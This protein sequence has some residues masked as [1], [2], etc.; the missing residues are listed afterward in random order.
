[1]PDVLS[2][3]I[4]FIEHHKAGSPTDANVYWIH[5]R[6]PEIARKFEE[7]HGIKISHRMIKRQLLVMNFRY[8]KLSK[9]LAT[10]QY[11][12]RDKQ[13][14]IIFE[15]VLLMSSN[16]PV[17]SIDCK[18]KERIGNLYR[19]GKCYVQ[20]LQRVYDHDYSH[21]SKGKVIPFGIYDWLRNEGYISIGNSAETAEFIFD[22]LLWWWDNFGIH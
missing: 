18:K 19:E 2:L 6:P 12:H 16:N 20:G 15:L 7:L 10:G 9:Q 8:R 14:K 1:M 4:V 21:L 13:F 22:N 5:L 3:L 17:V 11:A